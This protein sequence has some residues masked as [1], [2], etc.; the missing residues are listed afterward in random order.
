MRTDSKKNF[1]ENQVEI[2][3]IRTKSLKKS[4]ERSRKKKLSRGLTREKKLSWE[5]SREKIHEDQVEY[6]FMRTRS[7]VHSQITNSSTHLTSCKQVRVEL[8]DRIMT[9]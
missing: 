1:N 3:L 8:I 9:L 6:T 5:P 2:T 7:R 4:R